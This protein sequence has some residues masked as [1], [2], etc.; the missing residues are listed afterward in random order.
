MPESAIQPGTKGG[1]IP[2]GQI[3]LKWTKLGVEK[4]TALLK[5]FFERSETLE[6]TVEG[7]GANRKTT[8]KISKRDLDDKHIRKTQE[9][10]SDILNNDKNH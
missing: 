1:E 9:L 8:L 10:L 5:I 7:E 4:L 2:Y 6:F 3:A